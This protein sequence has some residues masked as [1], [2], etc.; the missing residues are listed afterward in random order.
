MRTLGRVLLSVWGATWGLFCATLFSA[1]YDLGRIFT[2]RVGLMDFCQETF[3]SWILTGVGVRVEVRGAENL[4][5]NRAAIVM[6]NHRSLLDIPVMIR[7]IPRIRFVAKKE[8]GRIPIF[9]WSLALSEHVLIDRNDR[10]SAIKGLQNMADVFRRGRNLMVFAEGTRSPSERLLPF[11]KGGF[12]IALDTGLPILPVSIEGNQHTLPKGA[13]L[14]RPG[15]LVVTVHPLVP[16][17][18]LS[19]GDIPGLMAEVR[20]AVLSGLPSAQALE[21]A[22]VAKAS[23]G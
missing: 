22:P 5:R 1:L 15:K 20:A 9:G 19:R 17:E 23:R 11:K 13:V 4:D 6:A 21:E 16:V 14:L 12:H 2:R 18:G 3:A 8:L 10:S 7:H